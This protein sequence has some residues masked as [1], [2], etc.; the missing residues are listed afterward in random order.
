MV[1]LPRSTV[2]SHTSEGLETEKFGFELYDFEI[3]NVLNAN[4]PIM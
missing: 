1:T 3:S 4:L 2:K